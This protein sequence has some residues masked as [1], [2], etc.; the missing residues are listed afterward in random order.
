MEIYKH[1]GE[2]IVVIP[3]LSPRSNPYMEEGSDCGEYPTL[4]GLIYKEY[5]NTQCAFAQTIDMDYKGKPDQVGGPI[6]MWYGSEEDFI[7][8]C[9]E[10]GLGIYDMRN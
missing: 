10:L 9:D 4:T 7:K 3:E 5:G 2:I 1:D 8:K 6:I